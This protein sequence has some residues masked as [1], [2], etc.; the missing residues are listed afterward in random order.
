MIESDSITKIRTVCCVMLNKN[1]FFRQNRE[2][3]DG[4]IPEEKWLHQEL[5]INNHNYEFV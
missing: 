4:F 2:V 1:T 3:W 5:H